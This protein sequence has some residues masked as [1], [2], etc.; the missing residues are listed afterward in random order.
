MIP[1]VYKDIKNIVEEVH[2]L[3]RAMTLSVRNGL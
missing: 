2:F 1:Y 3:G